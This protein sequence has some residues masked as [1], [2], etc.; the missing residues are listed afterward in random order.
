MTL[1]GQLRVVI[2]QSFKRI[3]SQ[4]SYVRLIT[5][6]LDHSFTS[7]VSDRGNVE[8]SSML[9]SAVESQ[10]TE[11]QMNPQLFHAA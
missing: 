11:R 8:R 6:V 5:E 2:I 7:A 9:F 4:G 10:L 1:H 3:A